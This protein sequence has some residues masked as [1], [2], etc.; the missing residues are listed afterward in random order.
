MKMFSKI[1][2]IIISAFSFLSAPFSQLF[3]EVELKSEL[4]EGNYESP[5]IVR[6]LESITVNGVSVEEYCIV[7]PDSDSTLYSD[8]A[9]T[10][11]DEIYKVCGIKIQTS[12]NADKTFII[13]NDLN[14]EDNFTLA[15]ENGK[16]Y[17]E[18][19]MYMFNP[20]RPKLKASMQALGNIT[21]AHFDFSQLS[22]KYPAYL[23]G[24]LP[25]IFNPALATG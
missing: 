2:A 25:N 21:S 23:A 12:K 4:A 18:A 17:I 13:N 16:V 3:S 1:V 22:S 14:S 9:N 24:S 20:V 8:A 15:V 6:P 11:A 7:I 5:Y 19:I 10:L